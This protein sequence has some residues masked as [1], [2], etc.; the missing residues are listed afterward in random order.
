MC[1]RD[2]YLTKLVPYLGETRDYA[3]SSLAGLAV[4]FGMPGWLH[5][6]FFVL[7]GAAVA[8][9]VLGLARWRFSDQ[10]LY[11]ALSSGVLLAG[12]CLLSSLGQAYYSMMLFPALFTV[13]HR[14][15]PMHTWTAWLGAVL[16][17]VPLSWVTPQHP[18][19]GRWLTTF[20]PT[21][22]WAVFILAVAAWVVSVQIHQH[23]GG[24]HNG[25]PELQELHRGAVAR[26]AQP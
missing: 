8:V 18:I 22:G 24:Q 1:I 21:A 2:S 15:S 9:A 5:A 3:N 20:M 26:E 13:L 19:G 12:V 25:R 17:L 10:W 14:A 23:N 7:L 11:L 16:C 4:Y 6:T